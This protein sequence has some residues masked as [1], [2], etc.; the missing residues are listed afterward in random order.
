[1][2]AK[3]SCLLTGPAGE[4]LKN[5]GLLVLRI[6][7]GL[8][9]LVLHGWGKLVNHA[10]L[11]QTFPDLF[12]FGPAVSAYLAIMAEVFCAALVVVGFATRLA[13]IPLIITMGVAFFIA[14]GGALTGEN[15]GE[16]AFMYLGGY[17]ALLLAGPGRFSVDHHLCRSMQ[18][19]D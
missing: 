2:I 16:L 13:L 14:H 6:W 18:R 17:I 11:A 5:T 15:S 1:M 4:T 9:M 8:S 7:F 12:G 19:A 10:E 3:C